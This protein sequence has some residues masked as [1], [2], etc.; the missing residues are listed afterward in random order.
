MV[1]TYRDGEIN[2][3]KQLYIMKFLFSV[4]EGKMF[5]NLL[6]IHD[7]ILSCGGRFFFY[8]F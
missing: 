1:L 7:L 4:E 6:I 5:I 3:L 2:I 8:L